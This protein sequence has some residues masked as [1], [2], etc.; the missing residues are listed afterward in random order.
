MTNKHFLFLFL[1]IYLLFSYP[2]A[3]GAWNLNQTIGWQRPNRTWH[4]YFLPILFLL[5]FIVYRQLTKRKFPIS[6]K[7]FWTHFLLAFV[8]TFFINY[9][10][11]QISSSWSSYETIEGFF[12]RQRIAISIYLVVNLGFYAFLLYQSLTLQKPIDKQNGS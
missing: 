5:V 3:S 11:A 6:N 1:A 2:M 9:P 7:F 8:P 12:N 10:F 4:A